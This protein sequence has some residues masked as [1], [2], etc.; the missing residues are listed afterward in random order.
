MNN[1]KNK[2]NAIHCP[3]C[4]GKTIIIYED[5]YG[6]FQGRTICPHCKYSFNVNIIIPEPEGSNDRKKWATPTYRSRSSSRVAEK[7][8]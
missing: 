7:L 8:F 5:S 1:R 6:T 4:R 3:N 2:E